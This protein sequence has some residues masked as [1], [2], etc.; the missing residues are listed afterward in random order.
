MNRLS[1]KQRRAGE[2]LLVDFSAQLCEFEAR[3]EWL[4]SAIDKLLARLGKART[5]Q[6]RYDVRRQ[7]KMLL[8]AHHHAE[9]AVICLKNNCDVINSRLRAR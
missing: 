3:L 2:A 6:Q 8:A 7:M 1:K 9:I 5:L 4:Q